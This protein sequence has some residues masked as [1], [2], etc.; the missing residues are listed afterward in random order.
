MKLKSK[1]IKKNMFK[2]LKNNLG[3]LLKN[4]VLFKRKNLMLTTYL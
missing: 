1:L 3:S 2:S 4:G